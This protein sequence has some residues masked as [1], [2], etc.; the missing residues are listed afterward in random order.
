MLLAI[1][2]AIQSVLSLRCVSP[3]SSGKDTYYSSAASCIYTFYLLVLCLRSLWRCSLPT[4]A[5]LVVHLSVLTSIAAIGF[6][7]NALIPP[8]ATTTTIWRHDISALQL[9]YTTLYIY[10]FAALV[11][12]TIQRG[13]SLW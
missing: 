5:V 13:P 1:A 2:L 11:A 4:H 10:F 8:S 9:W 3:L 12:S 7:I 6:A